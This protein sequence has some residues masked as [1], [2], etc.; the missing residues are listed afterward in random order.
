MKIGARS[1]VSLG[2]Q[3]LSLSLS[4]SRTT[5]YTRSTLPHLSLMGN[6][7]SPS[8][9]YMNER[10][11]F[12][13]S[14]SLHQACTICRMVFSS[15][16]LLFT[17]PVTSRVWVYMI[18]AVDGNPSIPVVSESSSFF[19][20]IQVS[21]LPEHIVQGV[22]RITGSGIEEATMNMQALLADD[23]EA[24]RASQRCFVLLLDVFRE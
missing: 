15:G 19:Y 6:L 5:T 24:R 13:L 7:F 20:L 8:T 1:S 12:S 17:R 9:I 16:P 2:F 18:V 11:S 10:S 22:L 3:C 21:C 4:L 14:L 23:D